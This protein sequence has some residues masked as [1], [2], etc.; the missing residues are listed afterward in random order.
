MLLSVSSVMLGEPVLV[1]AGEVG[2]MCEAAL[3]LGDADRPGVERV[4]DGGE[5][6]AGGSAVGAGTMRHSALLASRLPPRLS[7]WRTILPEDAST[8]LAPHR[9][10]EEASVRIRSGLSPAAT[11]NAEATSGPTP[12]APSSARYGQARPATAA[13]RRSG[14]AVGPVPGAGHGRS[15]HRRV[16]GGARRCTPPGDVFELTAEHPAA[17]GAVECSDIPVRCAQIFWLD[18]L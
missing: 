14:D 17:I 15:G 3:E 16:R 1:A 18:E 8:G 13:R 4:G 6:D 2:V 5:V 11:S 7:R 9:A 12:R 10:A